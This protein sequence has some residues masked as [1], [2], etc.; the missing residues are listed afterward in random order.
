[1]STFIFMPIHEALQFLAIHTLDYYS[2]G[3]RI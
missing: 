3:F 2:S 1:M